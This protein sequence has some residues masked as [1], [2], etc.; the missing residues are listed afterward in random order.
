M[1]NPGPNPNPPPPNPPPPN[2]P[3][4]PGGLGPPGPS[5]AGSRK[6]YNKI[7]FALAAMGLI[8]LFSILDSGKKDDSNRAQ[9]QSYSPE[10]R[11][12][13]PGEEGHGLNQFPKPPENQAGLTPPVDDK[14][15]IPPDEQGVIVVGPPQVDPLEEEK[16]RNEADERR[17][18][19]EA[20]FAALNSKLLTKSAEPARRGTAAEPSP[21]PS[22]SPPAKG[23]EVSASGE[24]DPAA[25]R[26]KEKFL[27]R[28]EAKSWLS[29]NT[30]ESGHPYEIK[31]GSVIPGILLTAINS[32]LPGYLIAQV[33]Q[34]VFDSATGKSLLIPQ[35][36]KLFGVY[37]SRVVYGQERVLV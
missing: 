22:F 13:L 19:R 17:R 16:K 29:P 36:S 35:G 8:L 10:T 11:S 5:G 2:P 6:T 28:T 27:E 18:K 31:T 30:R 32:D 4:G 23:P 25:D 1:A 24:Y 21:G 26:D 20:Y 37:D 12:F 14:P 15:I 34:N 7:V 9:R 3:P 33:S